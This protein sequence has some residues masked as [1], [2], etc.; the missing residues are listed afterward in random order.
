MPLPI[1]LV[2]D[3]QDLASPIPLR[4]IQRFD[5]SEGH[6]RSESGSRLLITL[7]EGGTTSWRRKWNAAGGRHRVS[8]LS[9]RRHC[10]SI[11]YCSS[12][13]GNSCSSN[14]PLVACAIPASC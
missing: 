14:P 12:W 13:G 8:L 9:A 1:L 11:L 4:P 7:V 3:E 5:R 6:P 2:E 10:G